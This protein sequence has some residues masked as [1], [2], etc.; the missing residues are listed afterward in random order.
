MKR[1][2]EALIKKPFVR[3]VFIMASGT[4][5][6]QAVTMAFSP[7]IT[8]LYGPEAFGLMG[9]FVAIVGIIAPIAAL[10]YPIAIVLPKHDSDAKGIIR[11]S[12]Y[13]SSGIAVLTAF[14]LFVFNKSIVQLFQLGAV[15]PFLFLIPVVIVFSGFLQVIEQW[16]IRT[17][18]FGI[19]AKVTFL[20][21]LFIQGSKVGIGFF[22]P[23]AAVLIILSAA[24]NGLKAFMLML[25][26]KGSDYNETA[27]IEA[28]QTSIK[29]IAKKHK[30]FPLYRAPEVFLN[31]TSQSLPILLLTSFFGPASAGFYSIGK[32]VLSIPIQLI[33]KSVGNVFYPRISE[34]A[35]KGE[36][37]THLI[38]KATL[39]LGAVGV[40]PFGIIVIF[41]PWLFSFVFGAEW[42]TAGEYARWIALWTFFGFINR[43]SVV[44]LP[45]LA[46]QAFQLYFT[47]FMLVTR[48]AALAIGYYVFL[49]DVIAIAF[50]GV[51]GAILN[52]SL[53]LITLRISKNYDENGWR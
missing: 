2:I 46:A 18:Q 16:L 33:G 38:K 22:H 17:K 19:T 9:V 10:T 29:D 45:V 28:G 50:F 14:I 48:V 35:N 21:A 27:E 31:T 42:I 13:I 6:A 41:G 20:Q 52:I 5:A 51:S 47:I 26:A 12:L 43:P 1:K 11:L 37:L 32:T 24:G 53:I 7:F 40:I 23:V 25:F 34:A 39:A 15:A 8:R 36:N 3:N 44:S 49:S 30:D 4:A